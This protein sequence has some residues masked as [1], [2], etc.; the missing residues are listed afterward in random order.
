MRYPTTNNKTP[1]LFLR[2]HIMLLAPADRETPGVLVTAKTRQPPKKTDEQPAAPTGRAPFSALFGGAGNSS[3]SAAELGGEIICGYTALHAAAASGQAEA[4]ARLLDL[5]SVG[6]NARDE[7]GRSALHWAAAG[8][9][10]SACALL[11]DRG[12]DLNAKDDD[13][14]TAL[15]CAAAGGHAE[16]CALLLASGADCGLKTKSGETAV[17]VP[18]TSTWRLTRLLLGATFY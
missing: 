9:H 7:R 12:A 16:A 13:G 1:S 11:R 3:S 2:I 17:C 4:C 18:G 6:V 8:G 10:A 5:P 15:H 14:F